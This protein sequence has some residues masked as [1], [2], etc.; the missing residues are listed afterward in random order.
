MKIK[1]NRNRLVSTMNEQASI[2]HTPGGGLHRLALSDED[3]EV[4]DWLLKKM[5]DLGLET[6]IDTVGNMFGRR[7]GIDSDAAPVLVGSHLDSQPYG[8]I[9]DGALG[10]VSSLELIQTLND[11][12]IETSHPIE[13]VNWT[14]EEGSRFQPAMQGSGVW[15]GNLDLETEYAKVDQSGQTF[16][17]EL[18]RIGYKGSVPAEPMESYESALELHIEQGTKLESNDKDVG[19]VSGIVGLSWGAVTF[20]GEATHTGTTPMHERRDALVAAADLILTIRRLAGTLGKD[21]VASVGYADINPNSINVVPKTVTVTWGIRDPSDGV[22]DEGRRKILEATEA[23]AAQEDVEFEY[24]DRARSHSIRFPDQPVSAIRH[25]AKD[26]E[27][28]NMEIF[29]GAVHDAANVASVCETGMVF[30][31]SKDGVSHTEDEF[32]SWEDCYRAANTFA[33]ATLRLAE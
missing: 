29:S 2:G 27:Y 10:V 17:S 13:I 14:N 12:N 24:E 28:N 11:N 26:L 3:K 19:V 30:A 9:Y 5:K 25:A 21:T 33:N 7:S 32:T 23:I 4:R 1:I 31:V 16:E 15:A 22:V 8:G 6:R 18:E 20:H